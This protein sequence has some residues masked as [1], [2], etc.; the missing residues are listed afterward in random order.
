MKTYKTNRLGYLKSSDNVP[1][2]NKNI[3][4]CWSFLATG[5]TYVR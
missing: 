3:L 4:L 5:S 2:I 1:H